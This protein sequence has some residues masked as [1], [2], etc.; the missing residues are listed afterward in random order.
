MRIKENWKGWIDSCNEHKPHLFRDTV[1]RM[2]TKELGV[3]AMVEEAHKKGELLLEMPFV[4]NAPLGALEEARRDRL[5]NRFTCGDDVRRTMMKV[6]QNM[7][8]WLRENG[9][10]DSW[11]PLAGPDAF[12]HYLEVVVRGGSIMFFLKC[13]GKYIWYTDDPVNTDSDNEMDRRMDV[14]FGLLVLVM[15][16]EWKKL[17]PVFLEDAKAERDEKEHYSKWASDIAAPW[18]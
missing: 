12:S 8:A 15:A 10:T 4:P 6:Y 7:L 2:A 16:K 13:G 5:R 9:V 11:Q 18:L 14:L 3:D 1:F 17:E